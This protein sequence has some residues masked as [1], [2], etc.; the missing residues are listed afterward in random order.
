M[1]EGGGRG[2]K[3][4]D[5]D[6]MAY[7]GA[8]KAGSPEYTLGDCRRGDEDSQNRECVV[9]CP[10]PFP[11]LDKVKGLVAIQATREVQDSDR[12]VER[13]ACN[14]QN[15]KNHNITLLYTQYIR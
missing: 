1:R 7:L 15:E 12:G 11:W 10:D 3:R 2:E 8:R 6:E 13:K 4:V 14:N 9:R 5:R